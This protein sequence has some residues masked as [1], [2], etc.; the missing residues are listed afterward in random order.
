MTNS[1]VGA[2]GL[3]GCL[4]LLHFAFRRVVEE[5][6]RLLA[7]RGLARAHHR[8]LYFVRTRAGLS[9][10]DLCDVLDVSKQALHRPLTELIRQE[11]VA[12]LND[13][14]DGRRR[15]L[16][17]T[18]EGLAFEARLSGLQRARFARAF[19]DAGPAA[20]DGWREVMERLIATT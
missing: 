8:V 4:E 14:Q 3:D 15:H 11:L 18:E 9:V 5:P 6:D 20:E 16:V 1:L 2:E 19:F 7:E 13:P 17:L 12:Q 10:G